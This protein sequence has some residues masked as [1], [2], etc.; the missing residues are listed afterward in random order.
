MMT[1]KPIN[2]MLYNIDTSFNHQR[3]MLIHGAM[4]KRNDTAMTGEIAAA[5]YDGGA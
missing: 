3:R 2:I 1:E 5:A 4:R